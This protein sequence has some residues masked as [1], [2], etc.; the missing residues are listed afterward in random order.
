MAKAQPKHK[1]TMHMDTSIRCIQINLQHSKAATHNLI[2]TIEEGDMDIVFAQELYTIQN[3][4]VGI[5]RTYKTFISGRG[6]TRAAIIL[7][8]DKIDAILINQLSDEDMVVVEITTSRSRFFTIS[9]YLDILQELENDTKKMGGVLHYTRGKG[10]IIGMDSNSRSRSWYDTVTNTR[11]IIL[12]EFLAGKQ[13]HMLN[14]ES[15]STT[16]K[17]AEEPVM[18]IL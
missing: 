2:Q 14:E 18:W 7:I 9:M 16:Y 17:I 13:L 6:K 12:E 8:N 10:V 11:G 1:S 15:D 4:L 5:P 3:K